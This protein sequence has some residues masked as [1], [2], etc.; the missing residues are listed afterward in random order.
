M[1]WFLL[2]VIT[3]ATGAFS[4]GLWQFFGVHMDGLNYALPVG[5]ISSVQFK[6]GV[7]AFLACALLTGI[8]TRYHIDYSTEKRKSGINISGD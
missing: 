5:D 7:A 6:A 2:L 4:R 8:L 1:Y 3:A